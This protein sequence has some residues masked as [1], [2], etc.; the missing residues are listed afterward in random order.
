VVPLGEETDEKE[1]R[2]NT[3]AAWQPLNFATKFC[4]AERDRERE[5]EKATYTYPTRT[6][7]G[8]FKF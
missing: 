4:G 8:G 2:R 5:R 1:K 3:D 7:R 6:G